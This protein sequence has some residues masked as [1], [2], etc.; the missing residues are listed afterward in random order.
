MPTIEVRVHGGMPPKACIEI[1][2][3]VERNEFAAL[4]FAENP[5]NRGILPA[6]AGAV[7]RRLGALRSVPRRFRSLRPQS[8]VIAMELTGL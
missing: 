6:A 7:S 3:A 1:A 5:F 2:E 8:N 4:W